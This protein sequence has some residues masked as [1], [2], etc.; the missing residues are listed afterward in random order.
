MAANASE[1]SD[2]RLA[3]GLAAARAL[4]ATEAGSCARAGELQS[5]LK[6]ARARDEPYREARTAAALAEYLQ[7]GAK[8]AAEAATTAEADL[9]GATVGAAARLAAASAEHALR[10]S[11]A[12]EASDQAKTATHAKESRA[13]LLE[14]ALSKGSTPALKREVGTKLKATQLLCEVRGKC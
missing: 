14:A 13:G 11:E 3:K 9:L 7:L 4:V 6:T 1:T 2:E 8:T 10:V 5:V 12:A